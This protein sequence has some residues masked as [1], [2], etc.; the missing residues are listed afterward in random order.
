MT[1]YSHTVDVQLGHISEGTEHIEFVKKIMNRS[2]TMRMKHSFANVTQAVCVDKNIDKNVIELST[3]CEKGYECTISRPYMKEIKQFSVDS[4]KIRIV[5]IANDTFSARQ[6]YLCL[7]NKFMRRSY[8]SSTEGNHM[9]VTSEEDTYS[10]IY[11]EQ[12][13]ELAIEEKIT[14]ITDNYFKEKYAKV[15]KEASQLSLNLGKQSAMERFKGNNLL[16]EICS[17]YDADDIIDGI[18]KHDNRCIAIMLS[19][20]TSYEYFIRRLSF[21]GGF[22]VIRVGRHSQADYV[23]YAKR[24]LDYHGFE[25]DM[26]CDFNNVLEQLQAYRGSLFTETDIYTLLGR[27]MDKAFARNENIIK[28]SDLS[29]NWS[30]GNKSAMEMLEE[31]VGLDIA[32]D[33]IKRLVAVKRVVMENTTSYEG[34][35]SIHTNMIFAGNPG[36]GKSKLARLYARMLS[37]I[38]L[39]NGCFEDVSRV[40]LVGKYVGHTAAKV[41]Q[42]FERARGGVIFVDEASFLLGDDSFVREAVVEFVRFMELYPETTVI[43]ATYKQE[44]EQLLHVDAGFRSRISKVVVFE[45]YEHQELYEIME[46]LARDFGVKLEQNCRVP[47]EEYI[48]KIRDQDGFANGREVRKLLESAMEEYG[49]RTH[50]AEGVIT[51]KDVDNAAKLLMK[52]REISPKKRI[53]FGGF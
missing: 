46:L 30:F 51:E 12:D 16:F 10:E 38:G 34:N 11:D 6:A 20:G 53:G 32:K 28:E 14:V 45:D 37:E 4:D 3:G 25:I 2:L 5:V 43:F 52:Q 27:G 1:E 23:E 39:S 8:N 7:I 47:M 40:D 35:S 21:E 42:V 19:Q 15:E 13:S 26:N 33:T 49:L 22:D 9:V 17:N 50:E 24:Y 36:T 48:E 31:V 18:L 29:L 41:N 44:A